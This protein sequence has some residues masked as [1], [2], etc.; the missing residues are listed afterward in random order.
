LLNHRGRAFWIG[1][2]VSLLL[3]ALLV[4]QIRLGEV[5][6]ALAGVN[7]L[8]VAPAVGIYFVAVF[9]RAVR[10]RYLLAP[11]GA[12]PVGRLYPVVVIGYA[13]NNL[14]P[15]RLGE[16]VRAY[17]LAQ[18]EECSTGAA[19]G[20][21]AVE[22]VYDGLTLLAVA[23]LAGLALLLLGYFDAAG[24]LSAAAL[25]LVAVIVAIFALALA[26][27]TLA[28]S[29]RF[30]GLIQ[31]ALGL[32]PARLQ[33][34]VAGFVGRFVQ[35]LLVLNSPRKH[36]A[37]FVLSLP[38]WLLEGAMYFLIIYAFGIQHSFPSVG[39]LVLAAALL[40][41]TSNLATALPTSIGGI[42]PFEVVAQQT[43]VALGVGASVAAAYAGFLHL[44]ALW[45]PVNL[46][47]LALLWKQNLSLGRLLGPSVQVLTPKDEALA[48]AVLLQKDR[49]GPKADAP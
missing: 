39:V 7:Y 25:A 45:L 35:G 17:Y 33:P 19:L 36:L 41:A 10:W 38:V 23:A 15:A 11:V 34:R 29:P 30:Q 16:L 48:P 27:L 42:G 9:F 8:Y 26:F 6:D 4:Y 5:L 46:A 20:T 28:A 47:G 1:L 43:L 24:G 49:G 12:F 13:A 21:V 44:V 40:T 32:V 22:R 3:L 18:R 14:L 2:A 31:R 37:V